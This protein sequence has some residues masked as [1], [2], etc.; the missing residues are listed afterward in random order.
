M[1]ENWI[2]PERGQS[3]TNMDG[4]CTHIGS[5]GI[6]LLSLLVWKGVPE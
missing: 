2:D 1:R 3:Q 4:S 5:Q 6:D